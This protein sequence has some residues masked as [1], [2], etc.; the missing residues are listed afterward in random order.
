ML[1]IIPEDKTATDTKTK[2]DDA[3]YCAGCGH[4]VTRGRW[5]ISMGGTERIF[6]NPMGIRF[7]VVCFA[8][9]PGCAA[10]GAPTARDTWFNGYQW[11]FALCRGCA[12]HLGWHYQNTGGSDGFFG[13]IKNQLSARPV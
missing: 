7:I 13:L 4:L 9:A 2:S 3:I 8:E 10:E 6:T 1:Q 5:K 12:R 11:D